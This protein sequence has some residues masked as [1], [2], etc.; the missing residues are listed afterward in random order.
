VKIELLHG[1]P[2]SR[3]NDIESYGFSFSRTRVG[4]GVRLFLTN[5]LWTAREFGRW[6]TWRNDEKKVAVVQVAVDTSSLRVDY[7]AFTAP[8]ERWIDRVGLRSSQE[9]CEALQEGLLPAPRN[10]YDWETALRVVYSVYTKR[11]ISPKDVEVLEVRRLPANY[12][13]PYVEDCDAWR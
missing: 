9:W 1:L 8:L 6:E 2:Y 5:D 12:R 7:R 10:Q 11:T 13:P 3:L 4:S